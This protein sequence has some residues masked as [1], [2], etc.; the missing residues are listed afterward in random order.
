MRDSLLKKVIFIWLTLM[1][2]MDYLFPSGGWETRL[3][4][5]GMNGLLFAI[6]FTENISQKRGFTPFRERGI[7]IALYLFLFWVCISIFFSQAPL[8][9]IRAVFPLLVGFLDVYIFYDFLSRSKENVYFFVK[10]ITFF[11]FCVSCWAIIES[12]HK[13]SIGSPIFKNIYAGFC[14]Q[15]F[16]GHFLFL[17]TPLIVSY[18]FINSPF[19]GKHMLWRLLL[20]I[21]TAYALILS[22]SR[23]SWNG[24]IMAMIFLLSWKSKA[25][26]VGILLLAIILNSSI[27]ILQGGQMYQTTWQGVYSDRA[28]AWN[29]YWNVILQN[30]FFGIGWGV[31]PQ[32]ALHAHNLYLSNAAQTGIFSII[33]ILAF[34]ISFLYSSFQ[35]E[36]RVTDLHLRAILLGCTATYFGQMFYSLTDL[37]G[38][39]VFTS[40]TSISFLPY[41]FIALPLAVGN[42]CQQQ[43]ESC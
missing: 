8:I 16:L 37:S 32:G 12:F 7:M 9:G 36:K 11:T 20:I 21:V 39:L 2:T 3:L 5:W 22:S 4:M 10:A 19:H 26:G 25:W 35:A 17:F 33:L 24:V 31:V 41:I 42:L 29:V 34:Y 30:P 14:N 15:N 43:E 6:W 23:S 1:C 28:A 40:A 27:Y 18:Y 13:L 38:I